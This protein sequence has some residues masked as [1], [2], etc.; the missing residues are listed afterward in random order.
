MEWLQI[1]VVFFAGFATGVVGLTTFTLYLGT[2]SISK[3]EKAISA[4]KKSNEELKDMN[5]RMKRVKDIASEMSA[6]SQR[7]DGPQKNGLDGK[8]KNN[9]IGQIKLLDEEKNDLLKSII[10]D[11]HDPEI[12]TLD[13][14]GVKTQMKLSEYM[15]YMGIFMEPKE[16]K[17]EVKTP[18]TEQIGKFTVIKGGKDDGG[19]TT[20]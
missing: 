9:I 5:A 13:E 15:A 2:K 17:P 6:L 14:S 11:G 20:H 3:K 18:R 8:F 16:S 19:N 4:L 1:A 10:R 12:T 7:I